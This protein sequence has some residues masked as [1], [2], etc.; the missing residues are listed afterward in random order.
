MQAEPLLIALDGPVGAGKSSLAQAVARRLDILHLDTGA[1][2]RAVALAA[3]NRG[4]SPDDEDALAALCVSGQARIDIRFEQGLQQTLLN[5]VPVDGQLRS[6]AVGKAASAVSRFRAVR[7]YLVARQQALAK[8]QSMIID[9]RD[10]GTVVLPQARA[11]IYITADASERARRRYEQIRASQPEASYQSILTELIARDKQ[12]ME[13][14]VT[15]LRRAED[16]VLLD[17]TDLDFNA[18][19]EAILAIVEEAYGKR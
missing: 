17:T 10:I 4:I 3:L 19:V 12:D 9:G 1:M 8:T 18:S 7:A 2:Y 6:E 16:A 5:G 11:K 14:E 15:P 13:R